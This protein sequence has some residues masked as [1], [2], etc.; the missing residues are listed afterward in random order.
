MSGRFAC[1]AGGSRSR[2]LFTWEGAWG[3]GCR[4]D[5]VLSGGTSDKTLSSG[6]SITCREV[7]LIGGS[8]A[9]SAEGGCAG[10]Q[11]SRAV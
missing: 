8:V 6:G 9:S 3:T 1:C 10:V 4:I 11:T 7:E 2:T 5:S